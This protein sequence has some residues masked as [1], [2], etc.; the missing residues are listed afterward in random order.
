MDDQ[1]WRLPHKRA[2]QVRVP[3]GAML[4]AIGL[5]SAA[6]LQQADVGHTAKENDLAA[7][8]GLS[9]G[10]AVALLGLVLVVFGLRATQRRKRVEA[11][12][13]E[14]TGVVMSTRVVGG[15]GSARSNHRAR[16]ALDAPA[17][18]V[19]ETTA[20]GAI[21]PV[22]GDSV[23]L[24]LDTH[25]PGYAVVVGYRS[26]PAGAPQPA[27]PR[28]SVDGRPLWGPV[29]GYLLFMRRSRSSI[30]AALLSTPVA[31]AAA[32]K[33]REAAHKGRAVRPRADREH[34]GQAQPGRDRQR[35][36]DQ[37]VPAD[38]NRERAHPPG[39]P[40]AR[41]ARNRRTIATSTTDRRGDYR[42]APK[43]RIKVLGHAD[44]ASGFSRLVRVTAV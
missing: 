39:V 38:N 29:S 10:G 15:G 43:P 1:G 26:P 31:G 7:T 44:H 27:A 16:I 41:A 30:L 35:H 42:F 11:H 33:P 32:Q 23:L 34:H 3:F 13:I 36:D 37:R 24:R 6:F 2:A 12:G 22:R 17:S 9:I 40:L 21:P 14:A 25:D 4:I 19:T 8:L 28:G 5:A 20:V 18:G